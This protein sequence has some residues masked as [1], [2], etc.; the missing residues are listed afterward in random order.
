VNQREQH[1]TS[2]V[3]TEVP[4]KG[5]LNMITVPTDSVRDQL[6]R[7]ERLLDSTLRSLAPIVA[8]AR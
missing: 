7:I 6:A 8:G 1:P 4:A 3:L 2:E 5:P